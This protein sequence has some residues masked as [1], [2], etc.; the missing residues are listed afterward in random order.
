MYGIT[1]PFNH[2]FSG[3]HK[4]IS[5]QI[6]QNWKLHISK[7]RIFPFSKKNIF[8]TDNGG[9]IQKRLPLPGK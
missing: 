1:L 3:G 2:N 5:D 7:S 9:N 8:L 4:Q 6:K